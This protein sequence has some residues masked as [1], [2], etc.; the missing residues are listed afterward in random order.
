[1]CD[2]Q[3]F[4]PLGIAFCGTARRPGP[5]HHC[6]DTHTTTL[7]SYRGKK[8]RGSK[9]KNAQHKQQ[10][11][12]CFALQPW[13]L[14]PAHPRCH[15]SVG[16][17]L[18]SL[19]GPIYSVP[20][21]DNTRVLWGGRGVIIN[22][23]LL[24]AKRNCQTHRSESNFLRRMQRHGCYA[25]SQLLISTI[26]FLFCVYNPIELTKISVVKANTYSIPLF[27]ATHFHQFVAE[28]NM[29]QGQVKKK[30]NLFIFC[31][32]YACEG[33]FVFLTRF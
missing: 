8:K 20:L 32:P 15:V 33:Y 17:T 24:V 19:S 30:K 16:N 1:M 31:T 26:H 9:Q 23:Q 10:R 3:C 21:Q 14:P 29:F 4:F 7:E 5:G 22:Y 27:Q 25:A 12:F 6:W 28:I 11:W 18:L 2:F 13:Q